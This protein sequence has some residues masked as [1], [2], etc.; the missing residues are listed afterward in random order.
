L[1]PPF[2]ARATV[3]SVPGEAPNDGVR[4]R[5]GWAAGFTLVELLVTV[6]IVAILAVIAVPTY[7][8]QVAGARRANMQGDLMRLAQ[9][10]ERLYSETGCYN[11]GADNDCSAGDAAN[12]TIGTNSAYYGVGFPEALTADTFTIRATPNA[13]GPQDGNGILEI[14]HL[15]ERFWD[16]N[17]DGD[18][19]DAGEDDWNRG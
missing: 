14:N 2:D 1:R 11:P 9:F 12:P 8:E 16:E 4:D 6:S 18:V 7:Q 19:D 15:G 3:L 10:M 5:N 13:N 17:N